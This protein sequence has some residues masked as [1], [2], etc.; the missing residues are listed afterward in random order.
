VKQKKIII[1]AGGTGGHITPAIALAKEFLKQNCQ[2]LYIGNKNSLEE[3]IVT[4]E[5]IKFKAIDVQ[6][7]YR[8]LTFKHLL[9]P[10]KFIR[11]VIKVLHIFKEFKPDAFIGIGGFVSGP[12]ALA[13]SL[14]KVPIFLQEQNSIPGL[15]NRLIGKKAENIF[16]GINNNEFPAEKVIFSGNPVLLQDHKE[17]IAYQEYGLNP[18]NKTILILG[19]SQGSYFINK[20]FE[21]IVDELLSNNLNIIWQLGN[22]SYQEFSEKLHGKQSVYAFAYT[23]EIEKI[24]NSSN[25]VIARAGALTL[26]EIETKRIPAILIPLPTAAKNHQVHNALALKKQAIILP[27]NQVTSQSL[28]ENIIKILQKPP[29]NIPYCSRHLNAANMIVKNVL[30][31]I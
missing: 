11:S 9:F 26:A 19:G 29:Q 20:S 27:Q 7:L 4:S 30:R 12:A 22:Y 31:R 3:S 28:L 1:S 13:A 10:S 6:K 5:N 18:H 17:K 21:P 15:T 16:L 24:Y 23:K 14:R 25:L 2:I 8:K